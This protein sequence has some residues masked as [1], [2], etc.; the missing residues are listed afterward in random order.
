VRAPREDDRLS[1]VSA[2]GS[3]G[4]PRLFAAAKLRSWFSSGVLSVFG[5]SQVTSESVFR[6]FSSRVDPSHPSMFQYSDTML[7]LRRNESNPNICTK[8]LRF[9]YVFQIGTSFVLPGCL[10]TH[11]F[12]PAYPC[13]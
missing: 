11:A 5:Y 12:R 3:Y 9:G 13:L 10:V 8:A 4:V 2:P 7:N 1:T 6:V